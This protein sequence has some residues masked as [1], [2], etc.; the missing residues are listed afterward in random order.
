MRR[1][2]VS[3]VLSPEEQGELTSELSDNGEA[4]TPSR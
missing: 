1:T 3:S 2:F 4:Q